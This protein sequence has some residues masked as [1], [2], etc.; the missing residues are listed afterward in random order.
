MLLMYVLFGTIGVVW[1]I[2]LL[3]L[4]AGAGVII[5]S[6][7]QNNNWGWYHQLVV[8]IVLAVA[9][10]HRV[11]DLINMTIALIYWLI[12]EIL[13]LIWILITFK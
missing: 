13:Y 12:S 10:Y 7:L 9:F 1:I 6:L 4:G 2:S 8:W 11:I 3:V 5:I